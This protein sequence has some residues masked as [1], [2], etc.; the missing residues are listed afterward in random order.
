MG[1][2]GALISHTA[3]AAGTYNSAQQTNLDKQG[4][5]CTFVTT[6]ESGSPSRTIAIQ[7]YDYASATYTTLVT[8]TN[9]DGTAWVTPKT[10]E[11]HP[12]I[13]T[14]SLPTN[15]SA[16]INLALPRF[17]R[18]QEVVTGAGTTTTGTVSC[19]LFR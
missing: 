5:A 10:V 4:V 8:S 13:Q 14:T 16:A 2:N 15:Y 1:V 18:V 3:A 19:N 12:G 7:G 6:G 17:W 9:A 11:V